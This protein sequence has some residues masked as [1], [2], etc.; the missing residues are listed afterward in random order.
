MDRILAQ[1]ISEFSRED[2]KD[3]IKDGF[4]YVDDAVKTRPGT[5][6]SPGQTIVLH[7][8]EFK[9]SFFQHPGEPP[10]SHSLR[11]DVS[12]LAEYRDFVFVYKPAG[13][14]VHQTHNPH[15]ISL[16]EIVKEWYPDI[17]GVG[18]P[19]S[20]EGPDRSGIVHRIDK[21]TSGVLVIA[22]TQDAYT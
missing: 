13:L 12:V 3:A 19:H 17:D 6:V 7:L 20:E 18:E 10:T 14:L 22:R 9:K 15:T 16:V 1:K 11:S 21:D 4:V 2:L 5:R 8:M